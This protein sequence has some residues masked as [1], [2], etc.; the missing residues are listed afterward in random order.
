MKDEMENELISALDNFSK[1]ESGFD[2]VFRNFNHFKP[3]VIF[4]DVVKNEGL[5]SLQQTL[6]NY[7]ISTEKPIKKD[8]RPFHPHVTI[9]TR[10]LHKKAFYEAWE[11]FKDKNYE[12]EWLSQEISILRHNKKN[13]DVIHTS[14]FK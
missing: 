14:Q 1:P 3:K 10:D 6:K 5:I 7:F 2:I 9:A 13:W 11:Y 4:I 8:D 12:A